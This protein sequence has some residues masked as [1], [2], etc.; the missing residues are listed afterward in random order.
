MTDFHEFQNTY[1]ASNYT[2][3]WHVLPTDLSVAVRFLH[4]AAELQLL[5]PV[6][7]IEPQSFASAH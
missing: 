6:L 1:S 7:R 2:Y 4:F 5:T 3:H